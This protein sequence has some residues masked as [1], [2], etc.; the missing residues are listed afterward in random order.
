METI[1]VT[2]HQALVEY[3]RERGIISGD[4]MV[5]SHATRDDVHGKRVIGVL[6][7]DLA[8][9]AE[10]VVV[11]ALDMPPEKR[12]HELTVEEIEQYTTGIYVYR[13]EK[14]GTIETKNTA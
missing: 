13:V 10:E 14:V 11:V 3:L 8:A 6:P 5:I 4:E 7:L 9:E 12:G 2:R 1:V